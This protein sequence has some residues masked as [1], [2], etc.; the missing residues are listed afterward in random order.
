M[1]PQG[2]APELDQP[3]PPLMNKE[4]LSESCRPLLDELIHDPEK[5]YLAGSFRRR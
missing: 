5:F 4:T 2:Q 3:Y 1:W